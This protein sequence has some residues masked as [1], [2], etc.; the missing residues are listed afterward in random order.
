M[1]E[2][3]KIIKG[4]EGAAAYFR[5]SFDAMY[6]T[7]AGEMFIEWTDAAEQAIC[8]LK[9]QEPRVVS[10][11]IR[12]GEAPVVGRCPNCGKYVFEYYNERFCGA[13]GQEMKWNDD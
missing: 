13:C 8:M 11:I 10:E 4:L 12:M 1:T 6:G 2:R 3:E 9:A 5:S 7:I